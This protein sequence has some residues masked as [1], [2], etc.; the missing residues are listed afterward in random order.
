MFTRI[1]LAVMRA[2]L[3]YFD[4]EITPH[5]LKAARPYFDVALPP[6]FELRQ[7]IELRTRLEDCQLR[8]LICDS[9]MER[10]L[11]LLK[12]ATQAKAG[13]KAGSGRIATVLFLSG[14]P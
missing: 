7:V 6:G 5:G 3:K 9:D 14:R 4:E 8:Y 11:P 12:S 10:T 2:A 13:V 1:D